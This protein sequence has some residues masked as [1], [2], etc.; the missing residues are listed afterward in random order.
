MNS[1]SILT[2]PYL[3]QAPAAAA[4]VLQSAGIHAAADFL[5]GVPARLAAP[6]VN[7]MI[8][9]MGARCLERLPPPH[10]AAILRNLP[11]HDSASLLRLVRVETRQPILAEL[12]TSLAKRLHRSLQ[13]SPN[14]VGAWID[15]DIPLL[16]TQ[17]T[18][19]DALQY[20]R[21]TRAASHIFLEGKDGRFTGTV[22]VQDLLRSERAATLDRLPINPIA[23][24][25]N[26]AALS[27]V[28]VLDAWDDHLMLPVVGRRHNVLGG[29]S[30][31]ALRRGVR[32]QH[33][34]RSAQPQTLAGSLWSALLL[35]CAGLLRLAIRPG[36]LLPAPTERRPGHGG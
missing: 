8:P 28:A 10:G 18:V 31:T 16:S 3:E 26:R 35:T 25:S 2:L 36:G 30:R 4:K 13:Y 27:S 9:A 17:H 14:A 24:I 1:T 23:P 21:E 12:P 19:E 20:L 7:S 5:E 11:T 6:L 29:L 32:E 15:P 22:S 33:E 34:A